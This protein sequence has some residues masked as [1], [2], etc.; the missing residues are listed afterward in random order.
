MAKTFFAKD[1]GAGFVVVIYEDGYRGSGANDLVTNP[2]GSANAAQ[3]YF[4]SNLSF[5]RTPTSITNNIT[6]PARNT[7]LDCSKKKGGCVVVPSYGS[8]TYTLANGNYS[9]KVIV[10]ADAVTGR[11]LG[12]TMFVQRVG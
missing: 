3:V 2:M 8:A 5:F 1:E 7:G 4:H 11:S 9:N 6:L 10:S 12:G